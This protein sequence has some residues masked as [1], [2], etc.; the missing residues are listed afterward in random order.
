MSSLA[1]D[2]LGH[3]WPAK[4]RSFTSIQMDHTHT[5]VYIYIYTDGTNIIHTH[6]YIYINMFVHM[7]YTHTHT[8]L[9]RLLALGLLSHSTAQVHQMDFGTSWLLNKDK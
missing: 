3:R 5:Q 4:S 8:H 7:T 9:P 1:N 6:T 2:P